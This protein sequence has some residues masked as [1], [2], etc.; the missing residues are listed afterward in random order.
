MEKVQAKLGRSTSSSTRCS[1]GASTCRRPS[2]DA[3]ERIIIADGRA[4][5]GQ[6]KNQQ[7]IAEAQAASKIAEARGEAEAT[8]LRAES[9]STN[10][11]LLDLE[12]A[13]EQA[14]VCQGVTTCVIG[15]STADLLFRARG[16]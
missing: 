10:R 7:T 15:G 6:R 4:P 9:Y 3:R 5:A 14:K 1:S 11:Q 12:I 2:A 16:Q 8:K 13:R